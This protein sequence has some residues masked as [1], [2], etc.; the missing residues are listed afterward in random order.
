MRVTVLTVISA[1][2]AVIIGG[3]DMS[4]KKMIIPEVEIEIGDNLYLQIKDVSFIPF[5]KG[6]ISGDY[7]D[8]YPDD[9][10][11]ADWKDENCRLVIR[12]KKMTN[13]H[14]FLNMGVKPIFD[15]KEYDFD[16]DPALAAEYCSL[17]IL[18]IEEDLSNGN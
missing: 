5:K 2:N 18:Q 14:D 11:E 10:A 3:I 7:E 6:Y 12:K 15:T 8:C 16:C 13:S 4:Y 9:P 17:I 1:V